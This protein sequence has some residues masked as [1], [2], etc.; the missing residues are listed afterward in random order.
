MKKILS[1]LSVG[2]LALVTFSCVKEELVTFDETRATAPVLGSYE[3]GEKALTATFTPGAFNTDFNQNMPVNHSLILASV[4]GKTVNKAL[5]ASVK[6][7]QISIS[8]TNLA[9]AL[10]A[11]GYQEGAVVSL[12]MFI[13]ASM[14]AANQ[15]NGR[16]GHVDSQGHI[17]INGFEVVVPVAQGNPWEEFT[18]KSKWSLIGSIAST[19]N[20]WNKDEP[21]YMTPDGTKHVAKN[22]KLTPDDQFKFRFDGKWDDNRG[23]PGDVEPYVMNAGDDVEATPNGKNLGVAAEGNYD[24]LYDASTETITITEAFQTYPGFDS[25]S[26]WGV[27]G[28]IASRKLNWD[29]DV[30][31]MTDGEWH[32]AEGVELTKGDQFKFRK[33]RKWD[34]NFGAPGDTEPFVV[35]LDAEESA[36]GGGKNLSVPEDGVYDLMV[37][38]EAG[39]YKVVVSLGGFSPLV[40]EGGGDEPGPD[41]PGEPQ[42]WSVIGTIGGDGWSKDIDLTQVSEGVWMVR[43]VE[44][45]ASDEFKLRADHQWNDN[46]NT[47]GPEGNS[48]S[49]IDETNP[50]EVFKPVIGEA[51]A[52][53]DKNIQIGVAG[54]YN[55]T[56]NRTE[57]TVL[58]EPYEPGYGLIGQINGTSWN[59]DFMLK[60]SGGV[61]V[62]DPVSIEGG[63]KVRYDCSWADED[64]YGSVESAEITVGQPIALT[65]PG[66]DIKPA[67]GMYTVMFDPENLTVTL[68]S[69][70]ADWYYHGQSELTPDWGELPFEKVSDTEYVLELKTVSENSEFVLKNGALGDETLWIGA[71]KTQELTDDKFVVTVG[72]EFKISDQKVN[73]V[74]PNP[75]E[76]KFI[77]NP[78]TMTGLIKNA[79]EDWYY[80]G[81]SE[82]TPDWGELPFE[83]VSD[84][85]YVL[86]LKTI[87][88]NSGFVLKN[89]VVG[90]GTTWIGPDNSQELTDGKYVV[91]IGEEF[92]ISG[93]KVDGVIATPGEYVFT[94]NPVA[95]TAVITSVRADWYYHGQSEENPDWGELP[96]VKVS[97][98]EYTLE[99]K[100]VSEN[101]GFVLKN[102]AIEGTTWIGPDNSQELTDGKFVVT[103]GE[104]FKIS[105]NKVDGLIAEPGEYLLTFNPVAMTAV[106]TSRVVPRADWYYHGQSEEN[107][108]WGELPLEKVSDTEYTLKLKTV[109]ENSGFVLKDGALE[110]TTWIGPD[111]TQELTDG[112]FVVPIGE[113]FKISADKVDG[114]IATPGE[115]ILTFN[116]VAMTAVIKFARED[117]YYHGQSEQTPDWGELPLVKVSD[118]E[119]TLELKTVSANSG[120]VLKNG[121]LEGTTWIGPDNTQELTDGKFVV[122]IGE[123]FKIS[124]DKVDGV[125]AEPGEYILTFNPVAM[126]AV[127]SVAV[128]ERA[129]WYY[130]G[131]SKEN[132]NWGE[133]PFVKVSDDEYYV[134]LDVEDNS[135]FVLKTGALEGT[136]WIGADAT[137]AGEDGKYTVTPGLEFAISENKV[138]GI[139]AKG[140]KYKLT[141]YPNEMKAVLATA[142]PEY[143]YHGQSKRTPNWGTVP[144]E[145]VSDE[146]YYVILEVEA[147]YGFVLKTADESTW[148]GAAASGKGE[149][150]KYHVVLGTEFDID[151]DKVDGVFDTA[152]LVKMTYNPKT[153][154]AV[155]KAL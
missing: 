109:S 115:Y 139:I 60:E 101:S 30:S 102:G 1:I 113:E 20:A 86:K 144:F 49:T 88:A 120:F 7:G 16:N 77:F 141:F 17:T 147:G 84:T 64:T 57:G 69:V 121:A 107:P 150:G 142:E 108:N 145:K 135:G 155:V 24:I 41:E 100:T 152:G 46:F 132:P 36:V 55:I 45:T 83:K 123:E 42:A 19:G 11:L 94:F 37:N 21:A 5:S 58:V 4:D 26:T 93:D 66:S 87:S 106:I 13:R 51:F 39:L 70:R 91:T 48:V 137:L 96:L 92:K 15:D 74:I 153:Q 85:E 154:K 33:D 131:Q 23:A 110:G 6:D 54:T 138:D 81:Q 98:T 68:M 50:Y 27:T 65:Q 40:G 118:T 90:D 140:G 9:K 63:F 35:T 134:I 14:Q 78:V 28:S 76:Y 104:E 53:G 29:K 25:K 80:H 79:R 97:D 125:I 149:D 18:E 32:V 136:T 148:F 10:V 122:K 44:V 151:G 3:L 103:I 34:E 119:Y 2:L 61:Y 128:P 56:Y 43:K 38:P 99:L 124:A 89:G 133:T 73:G 72:N 31:M 146:E 130:H 47:G 12:D 67:E 129:D 127:I 105:G 111:N 112:K 117:W 126:T 52:A 75:G 95:M 22:I 114:V 62:S 82:L 116:P 8:V 59:T 71:D 143:C